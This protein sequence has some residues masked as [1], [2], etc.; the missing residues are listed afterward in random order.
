MEDC[1]DVAT[2]ETSITGHGVKMPGNLIFGITKRSSDKAFCVMI[3]VEAAK[4]S[5]WLLFDLQ[6]GDFGEEGVCAQWFDE[7]TLLNHSWDCLRK[8]KFKI[9]TILNRLFGFPI[10]EPC[11]L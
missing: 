10:F 2:L 3:A 8:L 4:G 6:I 7:N 5:S 1:V 9:L 11:L